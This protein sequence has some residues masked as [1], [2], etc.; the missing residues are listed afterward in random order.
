MSYKGFGLFLDDI[1]GGSLSRAEK[2]LAGISGG[3]SKAL[4]A[5]LKRTAT[6]TESF[7]ARAVRSEYVVKASDFKEFTTSKRHITISPGACE[8]SIEFKGY[9]IPLV[10]FSTT[11]VKGGKIS[12]KVKRESARQVLDNAF[13]ARL[14]NDFGIYERIGTKRFPIRQLWGPATTQM[15]YSNEHVTDSIDEHAR[16]VFENRMEH[17]INRILAGFGK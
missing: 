10:R 11:V 9:H 14:G 15:M 3:F 4:S 17:E 16:E 12:T 8:A 13:A 7:A 1:G 5:A 6:S 2:L